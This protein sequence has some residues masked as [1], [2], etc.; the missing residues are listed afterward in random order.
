MAETALTVDLTNCDRE[1]IHLLGAV[2]PFG[3]LV[4][5]SSADWRVARASRNVKEWLGREP[6][7]LE[8]RPVGEV[9][10]ESAIQVVREQLQSAVLG[11]TVARA[12]AVRLTASGPPFDLA[13]HV[14][15]DKVVIECEP[16]ATEDQINASATVKGMVARL[17]QVGDIRAFY[18]VAAREL[19][20]LTGFDRVMVYRF[21]EDGSG[22]VIAESAETE[23]EPYLGLHYP[24]S[25]I[26]QQARLLYERN[27]LRI[28]ADVDAD[29][30][31]IEPQRD[32]AGKPLDLSMSTL[33]S[34][35][36]IHI[37]YLRNMGVRASMSVSILRQGRLWGL[38]ACHHYSPRYLPFERRTAAELFGQMFSLMME[39]R[40]REE[41]R[42]YESRAQKL[43]HRLVQVMAAEASRFESIV[44]HL[45]DIADLLSCDGIGVWLRGAA[46]LKG[47]APTERQFADLA[48]WLD[49]LELIDVR[50]RSEIGA[51]FPPAREF[52][53]R[54]AGML[55]VPLSRPARDYLVFFRKELARSVTWAGDPS[56]PVTV[57][58]FG[59][60]LT[61]RK[62]F[63]LWK[64]TVR[65]HSLPWLPVECR[66]A[67]S[68]RISLV[69]VIL[70]LSGLTEVERVQARERQD[71]LIAELNHRVRNIF[72]LIRGVIRQSQESTSCFTEF[73]E[74]VG[75]R[76][77]ALARA[78]DQI[79]ADSWGP[80]SL[81][82]LIDAEKAA[83]VVGG[84][85]RVSMNGPDVLLEPK[86]FTTAALVIHEM[87]TNSAKYGALST[88]RGRIAIETTVE[89]GGNLTIRWSEQ[90]G[91]AVERPTRRG[92]GTTIIERSIPYDL[93]GEAVLD[94]DPAGLHAR[95][96]IPAAYVRSDPSPAEARM[97]PATEV[98]PD[99]LPADVLIVEDNMII[100]LE[101][102][103]ILREIG[104]A[105]IRA[106]SRVAEALAAI[107]ERAPEFA[108]LDVNLGEE[109]SF[110]VAERLAERKL[111][112]VFATGY[113]ENVAVPIALS[114]VPRLRKPYSP[115][116][117]LAAIA[118]KLPG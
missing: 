76:I 1:P 111:R 73:T 51:E 71:L 24:A 91:P 15:A 39:N 13:V 30:S 7:D 80:A 106:T 18:R 77:H 100:A 118:G 38:F 93:Q 21:A 115:D 94:F 53:D 25:D 22:E 59:A 4:A 50:A 65:G 61:P 45:D 98:S 116:T 82:A 49:S 33:R 31:P 104:V 108:I 87:V 102:E 101:V 48:A 9:F 66:I 95:F 28:I 75:G 107:D 67:E 11:E 105:R 43:H 26:P 3:F 69:E 36:P 8:G 114:H 34:V 19:K 64:E 96:V 20:T 54:A 35:S 97:L 44:A 47:I 88:S 113:G 32:G 83:Y 70:R 79:T 85:D 112:F 12:F 60:R 89:T 17:Q 90:E 68:L 5:V 84:V 78:H 14:V 74:A 37:E 52:A 58:P 29:P 55:V 62:S 41:E 6:A 10:C 109:T 72:S 86:A 40:E 103:D 81:R 110:V 117:L 57:G 42:G 23:I 27:W 92:F 2:Q 16:S 56:K 46:T 63:E 99:R